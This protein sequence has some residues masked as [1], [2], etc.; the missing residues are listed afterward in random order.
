MKKI[1]R[2]LFLVLLSA[3]VCAPAY[4]VGMEYLRWSP[5]SYFKE[6]DTQMFRDNA[7]RALNEAADN[8]TFSWNNP[9]TGASGTAKP[10][11]TVE[12]NGTTCRNLRFKNKAGGVSG[13]SMVKFCKQPDGS[14]K[15]P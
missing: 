3:V 12:E 14:W 1:A 11:R 10:F 7:S 2:P 9:E 4:G 8:E 6:S 5:I 15:S 13:G